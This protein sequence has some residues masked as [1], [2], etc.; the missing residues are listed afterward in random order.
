MEE[1]ATASIFK[2][3]PTWW[4]IATSSPLPCFFPACLI[5][6]NQRNYLRKEKLKL[7]QN[8]VRH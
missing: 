1:G 2:M 6:E 3:V 7:K 4:L 5:K 8:A